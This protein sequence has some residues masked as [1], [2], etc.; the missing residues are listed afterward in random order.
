MFSVCCVCVRARLCSVSQCWGYLLFAAISDIDRFWL[1]PTLN[2]TSTWAKH[3]S[4]KINL[5]FCMFIICH[6]C[7]K[8]TYSGCPVVSPKV[9]KTCTNVNPRAKL[10]GHS[11]VSLQPKLNLKC[12][13]GVFFSWLK[14]DTLEDGSSPTN[15]RS[16]CRSGWNKV[17][18]IWHYHS[19]NLVATASFSS[20]QSCSSLQVHAYLLFQ[21]QIIIF[22][23]TLLKIIFFYLIKHWHTWKNI[24]AFIIKL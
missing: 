1:T 18:E 10:T 15:W 24:I 4:T 7:R 14:W 12:K 11:N 5:V 2:W 21:T 22:F 17:P 9:A 13:A 3:Q 6:G 23:F 16:M 19:H 20:S 8:N